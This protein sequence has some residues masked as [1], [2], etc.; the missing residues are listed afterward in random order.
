MSDFVL[1]PGI[2]PLIAEVAV[3]IVPLALLTGYAFGRGRGL[4]LG[5]AAVLLGL[6]A[7]KLYTDWFD[8]YDVIVAVGG[9]FGGLLV[10]Q[11]VRRGPPLR[12]GALRI[13]IAVVLA[14]VGLYKIRADFFDPY[15][16]E[17]SVLIFASAGWVLLRLPHLEPGIRV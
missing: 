6:S 14:I 4:G 2:T 11:S 12:R 13:P 17:L 1:S 3:A 9:I 10:A 15:D 8:P 5:F 7:F 16:L